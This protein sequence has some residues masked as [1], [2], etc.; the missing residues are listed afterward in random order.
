MKIKN[1]KY[2]WTK[3]KCKEIALKYSTR[4]EFSIN[5]RTCYS[6]SARHKWLDEICEHMEFIK[7]PS[8]YWTFERCKEA[9]LKCSLF[10]I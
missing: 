8:D 5:D 1:P 10:S 2:Y 6:I 4:G 9:A 3:D 7:K